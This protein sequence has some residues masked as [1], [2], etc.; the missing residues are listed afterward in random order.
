MAACAA[1]PQIPPC[2]MIMSDH[3]QVSPF[4]FTVNFAM[5][6]LARALDF[7]EK[8]VGQ[9]RRGCRQIVPGNQLRAGQRLQRLAGNWRPSAGTRSVG[10]AEP[11]PLIANSSADAVP[12]SARR[13]ELAP[14]D[15]S[16]PT[17]RRERHVGKESRLRGSSTNSPRRRAAN[18]LPDRSQP[19]GALPEGVFESE[20]FS[21]VR[22]VLSTGCS[23]ESE[24]AWGADLEPSPDG[25][26]LVPSI[27]RD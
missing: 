7:L 22:G 1:G 23:P 20:M 10:A 13:V 19:A 26:T 9:Q 12:C 15:A 21:H 27:A 16:V 24:R 18:A 11:T 5:R 3:V 17:H 8:P 25:G 4:A 2:C 6:A 14:A